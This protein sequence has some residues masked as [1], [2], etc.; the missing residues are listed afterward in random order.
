MI[1]RRPPSLL[2]LSLLSDAPPLA[3]RDVEVRTVDALR[4]AAR[5][6]AP[7]DRMLLAP[8]TYADGCY[9]EGVHGTAVAPVR[10]EARDP[11]KPP[12][13]Q[14]GDVPFHLN[15]CSHLVVDGL[16]ATGGAENNIQIDFSHH[17]VLRRIASRAVAGRG[18]CDGIKMPGVTD[19]LFHDCAV[20]AWGAE[21]SAVDMVGCARGLI[22]KCRFAYPGLTGQTANT[23]QPKGGTN[24]L[25]V[26]RCRFDESSH[27]AL[28][29]GGSTGEAFF[30]QKNRDAG[31]EAMDM[32]AMGNVIAGGGTAAAFVSCTRCDVEYNTIV[33]PRQ[34][35]L[36]I[37]REGGTK[38]TA[39]NGFARNLVVYGRLTEVAN[40]DGSVDARSFRFAENYWLNE[41]DPARSLPA[42]PAPE[43]SPAGGADPRLDA[44][45]RPSPG[46]PAAA[47]GAHAAGM[48]AAWAKRTA[49]FAWAWEQAQRINTDRHSIRVHRCSSVALFPQAPPCAPCLRGL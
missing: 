14:G 9:I 33:R 25:G 13:F 32:A 42:L 18:N 28:Q 17:L 10:I 16:V 24:G 30:H 12:V 1:A 29:F 11:A 44:D 45:F 4:A 38:P 47:Y 8:G 6:A 20:E 5:S 27:R 23:L 26:Y 43:A 7:G 22:M 37:L 21:G 36:R 15:A 46:S 35:V 3:A 34:S 48:E 19:F 39:G 31:Y 2:L 49:G 41:T 40:V